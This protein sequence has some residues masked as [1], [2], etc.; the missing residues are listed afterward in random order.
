MLKN[1]NRDDLVKLWS[2]VHERFNS[3]EPTE[4]KEREL[5]VEL[6]RYFSF[7]RHL[8]ELHVTW[9]HL[10]KKQTRLRIYTNIDKEFL[11]SGWR[12][13][14]RYNFN[15]EMHALLLLFSLPNS[16]YDTVTT[17]S[18]TSD[19]NK[20]VFEDIRD[21]IFG[22]D[23]F[24]RNYGEYLNSLLSAMGH[25]RKS[26]R[27]KSK[28]KKKPPSENIE[29]IMCWNCGQKGHIRN[30]CEGE[31]AR[32]DVTV[33]DS[34][35]ALLCYNFKPLLGEGQ[36]DN[37]G[38]HMGF[39]AQMW[40][41]TRDVRS[42]SSTLGEVSMGALE[43]RFSKLWRAFKYC[44]VWELVKV[45]EPREVSKLVGA[46]VLGDVR[47]IRFWFDRWVDNCRLCDRFPRSGLG[48]LG[49]EDKWRWTLSGDGE[50]AVKELA[51]LIEEKVLRVE[52]GGHEMLWN[53]LVPKKVN[54]FVWRDLRGRIPVRVEVDKRDMD[55]DS[56]LCSCCNDIV[57][58]CAHSLV[59]CDL[60]M[61]VWIKVFN[62]W[63][64]GIVNS[65]TIEEVFLD[66]GGVNVPISL[67][68]VWQAIIWTSGYY[69][70]KERN[71][72]VFEER[73][74][75]LIKLY[76]T[77]NSKASNGFQED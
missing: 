30:K 13:R 21:M 48:G 58:T 42:A 50:F 57:E 63:K 14:H 43:V 4:D 24:R 20:L 19:L 28:S 8:E 23:I 5:W 26:N 41:V 62:W 56:V 53:N 74:Q 70:W 72:R 38:Y 27:G 66:S 44:K 34:N 29:N 67:S 25:E 33:E 17:I 1:F 60:A 47:D 6:K 35:D 61:S 51:R 2:L 18:S 10:E 76:K 68:R 65:F 3:T 77:F 39:D 59:T 31:K 36:L 45:H 73:L 11:Y 40:K 52:I 75:V 22:E 37:E 46:L 71:A 64:V 55:L 49:V 16:W 7:G 69:I 15:D 9:A 12:R 54:V 32:V